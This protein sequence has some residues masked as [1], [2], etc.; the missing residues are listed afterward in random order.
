MNGQWT[1]DNM[2]DMNGKRVL[3]TGGSGGLGLETAYGFAQKGAE[4]V[5]AVR[6][7]EKGR[8]AADGL[9]EKFPQASVE[10][11]RLDLADLSS[12][13][14]FA[15]GFIGKYDA[16][17]VL[18]NNAGVMIPPY[19][20]TKD[21]FELQFGSNHL[22]HF[23]L[24]GRLLPLLLRTTGARV[25]TLSSIAAKS[26]Y[27][28]FNNLDGR[29]GYSAMK[30]YGQSKLANLLFARELQKRLSAVGANTISVACHPGVSNTNLISRG[31]GK[32]AGRAV[33]FIWGLMSQSAAMGALPT[34]YASTE[35]L[36]G[37]EYIGPTGKGGR[38]GY[39]G[40]DLS[41]DHKMNEDTMA[42][43]WR[44]SEELTGVTYDFSRAEN[45]EWARLNIR[46]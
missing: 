24:T 10:V 21:G 31:S 46:M 11:M 2:P 28:Y 26:G 41:V 18:V 16:L 38:K 35:N 32:Q 14:A 33:S 34:L 22:G 40:F 36:Y 6:N 8:Q 23:A 1:I 12:I 30:F 25:V 45:E 39:P 19:G 42:K 29:L 15:A 4:I 17:H 9:L 27:I 37:G 43:L 13:E 3:I 20:K 7:M 44:A 5:L